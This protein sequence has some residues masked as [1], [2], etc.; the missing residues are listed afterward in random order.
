MRQEVPQAV[1]AGTTFE[2]N[3]CISYMFGLFLQCKY[4]KRIS[5]DELFSLFFVKNT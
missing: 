1:A 5:H 3:S 4:S 2:D